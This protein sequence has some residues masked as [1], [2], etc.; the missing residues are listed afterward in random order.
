MS[1]RSDARTAAFATVDRLV[2]RLNDLSAAVERSTALD[3]SVPIPDAVCMYL[4]ADGHCQLDRARHEEE[5][6]HD[7]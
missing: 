6:G 7:I 5:C 3:L 4:T 2:G 1:R